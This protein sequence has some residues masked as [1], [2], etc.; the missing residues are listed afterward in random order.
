MTVRRR[1]KKNTVRGHRTHGQGDTKNRRGAGSRGGRGRAGSHKHKYTKYFGTFGKNKKKVIGKPLGPSI[2]LDQIEQMIPTWIAKE[3]VSKE[4]NKVII[5]GKKIGFAKI[6]A[7]GQL[8]SKVVFEN[9]KVSQKAMEKLKESGSIVKGLEEEEL[10]T[11]E[12]T[13][14]EEAVEEETKEP[15]EEAEEK[16]DG[17]S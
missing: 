7:R 2:N 8:K 5:D 3:K 14:E 16:A 15:K 4:G 9:F 1:K 10:E 13:A 6:L 12:E 11:V 17:S